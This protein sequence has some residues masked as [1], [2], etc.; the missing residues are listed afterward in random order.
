MNPKTK[1]GKP[2]MGKKTRFNPRTDKFIVRTR[3]QK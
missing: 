1:W 2:A 3:K